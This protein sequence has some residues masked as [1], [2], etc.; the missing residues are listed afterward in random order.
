MNL[1]ENGINSSNLDLV[2]SKTEE[3]FDELELEIQ[4]SYWYSFENTS[5]IEKDFNSL[6]GYYISSRQKVNFIEPFL[7]KE[8][9]K[10]DVISLENK[11]YEYFENYKKSQFRSALKELQQLEQN[12]KVISAFT[13]SKNKSIDF[14]KRIKD[15][16]RSIKGKTKYF[17]H[18]LKTDTENEKIKYLSVQE[19]ISNVRAQRSA[20]TEEDKQK[21][22]N[23]N[24]LQN[25]NLNKENENYKFL[26]NNKHNRNLSLREKGKSSTMFSEKYDNSDS[27]LDESSHNFITTNEKNDIR[28]EN[29]YILQEI[30]EE[31]VKSKK[32][33]SY[34]KTSDNNTKKNNYDTEY[35]FHD[36]QTSISQIPNLTTKKQ[37]Y[38]NNKNSNGIENE[39]SSYKNESE[40]I[41]KLNLKHSK[42]DSSSQMSSEKVS[43]SLSSSRS[44][45][46]FTKKKKNISN[47]N[48]NLLNLHKELSLLKLDSVD[49][50]F[51]SKEIILPAIDQNLIN[52]YQEYRNS[53]N[54]NIF[55]ST[56]IIK[57]YN[58]NNYEQGNLQFIKNKN[59]TKNEPIN[60]FN[61]FTSEENFQVEK[62]LEDEN[63]NIIIKK[64]EL[65]TKIKLLYKEIQ[66][67]RSKL[68]Q[69][70]FDKTY[71]L[72]LIE[73]KVKKI[74]SPDDKR[75]LTKKRTKKLKPD[76]EQLVTELTQKN[77]QILE[78]K[79]SCEG[80]L[81]KIQEKI[82]KLTIFLEDLQGKVLECE[83]SLQVLE[84]EHE[85]IKSTLILYYLN[86][87]SL[88]TDVRK[89]GL[90][91][92]IISIWKLDSNVIMSYM[93]SFFDTENVEFLFIKSH[94]L[95]IQ[96]KLE[97]WLYKSKQKINDFN[98]K[99]MNISTFKKENL[100]KR[101]SFDEKFLSNYYKEI[102]EIKKN[103]NLIRQNS[104][105]E[106]NN[107]SLKYLSIKEK[108]SDENELNT[109]R[110]IDIKQRKESE[111]N[112][113]HINPLYKDKNSHTS[114]NLIGKIENLQ[115]TQ[116]KEA[117]EKKKK[118]E[119]INK[120]LKLVVKLNEFNIRLNK[121]L[122]RIQTIEVNRISEEHINW[123]YEEKYLIM[124]LKGLFGN[125][126]WQFEYHK[127]SNYY[128]NFV[129]N[130]YKTNF[131][132]KK[133]L[134]KRV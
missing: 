106:R 46:N 22:I 92:I 104:K 100:N 8:D 16:E 6:V 79:N 27:D 10:F 78:F 7:N 105:F 133:T 49:K 76:Q 71:I 62:Q 65:K 39:L 80:T 37:K 82:S 45:I 17:S 119:N 107:F 42:N 56:N 74:Q 28:K 85:Q 2:N 68:N 4:D 94:I 109:N 55:M 34:L 18:P 5:K 83:K 29:G 59:K 115:L 63:S 32:S 90:H 134:S 108:N 13:T 41:L 25:L 47:D 75:H 26:E 30:K 128:S 67:I 122:D 96:E 88:G 89:T 101:K 48:L 87:L 33:N 69:L 127:I 64:D 103:N 36:K 124:I 1:K 110:S 114:M 120:Y 84:N 40:P 12:Y 50:L 81:N 95:L 58:A 35:I 113:H 72:N 24:K 98:L 121:I 15:L 51:N 19:L 125:K 9:I 131:H 126:Y 21:G 99:L 129:S 11:D 91:W 97:Y 31:S 43:E 52:K 112:F 123:H 118:S 111:Y 86:L 20:K 117:L 132:E 57:K 3:N 14:F 38:F 53:V 54:F 23:S 77:K 73:T 102:D 66:Q 116:L 44:M 61:H 60:N 70:K 130:I 93:P